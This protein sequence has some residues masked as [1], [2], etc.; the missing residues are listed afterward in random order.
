M[1]GQIPVRILYGQNKIGKQNIK[2]KTLFQKHQKKKNGI[3]A[4][5]LNQRL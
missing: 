2:A 4:V 1:K 5:Y 3:Y